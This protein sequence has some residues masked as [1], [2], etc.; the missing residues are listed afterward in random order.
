M[1]YLVSRHLFLLCTDHRRKTRQLSLGKKSKKRKK[2]PGILLPAEHLTAKHRVLQK[3]VACAMTR[4]TLTGTGGDHEDLYTLTARKKQKLPNI[5]RASLRDFLSFFFRSFY[6]L[7][8]N[9]S[10]CR[11]L[12]RES[13]IAPTFLKL[14]VMTVTQCIT[15]NYHN[16]TTRPRVQRQRR[17]F[18][19][20]ILWL[21]HCFVCRIFALEEKWWPGF[22]FWLR[23]A[24][25]IVERLWCTHIR[26]RVL[27]L[28][29][30]CITLF[31]FWN[32]FSVLLKFS[33]TAK[34]PKVI[35]AD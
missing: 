14:E 22:L 2:K 29:T 1:L 33:S 26:V 9:L 12:T 13:R 5:S 17:E 7:M 6:R 30:K 20:Y 16:C 25:S 4:N 18:S 27:C 21:P 3:T 19:I 10:G 23:Y 28:V 24:V 35:K 32:V 31:F 11:A 34:T 15:K 8:R